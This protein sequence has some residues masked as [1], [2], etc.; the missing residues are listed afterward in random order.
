MTR[1]EYLILFD[2]IEKEDYDAVEKYIKDLNIDLN[3]FIN[4][5]T[6][7]NSVS[8]HGFSFFSPLQFACGFAQPKMFKLLVSLGCDVKK[9]HEDGNLFVCLF[10]FFNTEKKDNIIE[11][12]EILLTYNLYSS[13]DLLQQQEPPTLKTFGV[14]DNPQLTQYFIQCNEILKDYYNNEPLVKISE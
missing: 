9:H 10:D 12:F 14:I 4:N 2:Y 6:N 8:F 13:D 3:L 7:S 11:M 5:D 1:K